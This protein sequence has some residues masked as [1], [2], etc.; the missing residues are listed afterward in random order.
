[1]GRGLGRQDPGIGSTASPSIKQTAPHR[2]LFVLL[3]VRAVLEV[4]PTDI[5]LLSNRIRVRPNKP[6][7]SKTASVGFCILLIHLP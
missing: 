5:L 1:M 7:G 4:V 2:R 6:N 3:M